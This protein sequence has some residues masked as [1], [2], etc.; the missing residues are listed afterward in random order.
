MLW[1]QPFFFLISKS[2]YVE[3]QLRDALFKEF[4]VRKNG[5]KRHRVLLIDLEWALVPGRSREE[6]IATY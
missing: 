1:P 4:C 6:V 3:I 5:G 2:L